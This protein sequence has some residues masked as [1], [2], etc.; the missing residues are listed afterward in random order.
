MYHYMYWFIF[1][2]F[3]L[4]WIKPYDFQVLIQWLLVFLELLTKS[5]MYIYLAVFD[6]LLFISSNFNF[7]MKAIYR[8]LSNNFSN[9]DLEFIHI[10][11][12]IFLQLSLY[13][14][15]LK[16]YACI[17]YMKCASQICRQQMY[18]KVIMLKRRERIHMMVIML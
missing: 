7:Q 3:L 15:S 17:W 10:Q 8:I 13:Q 5:Y 12:R 11:L 16:E 1:F 4:C 9:F 6:L 18:M 2:I 14:K